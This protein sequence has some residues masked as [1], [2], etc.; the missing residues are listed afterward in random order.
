M[1]MEKPEEL[2]PY[3][4]LDRFAEEAKAGA[5]DAWLAK[6][7]FV[8][9]RQVQS[10]KRA[11][12]LSGK[13][14]VREAVEALQGLAR[15]YEPAA[16]QTG[17]ALDWETPEFVLR[18]ALDYTQ[19][20]RAVFSLITTARFTPRQV[21]RATGT[22]ESDVDQALQLWRRHLSTNGRRCLGCPTLVDPRFAEFCSRS[23]HD[24]ATKP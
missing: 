14:P 20:A 3:E 7:A 12:G 19:Y 2:T 11:R 21:A 10:W 4:A 22:R 5:D 24:R 1:K 23:C 17:Q 8:S 16:H 18:Q 6:K 13:A 9:V 15:A